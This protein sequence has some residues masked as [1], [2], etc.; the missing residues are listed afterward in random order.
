MTV[1]CSNYAQQY[2]QAWDTCNEANTVVA[3]TAQDCDAYAL[4]QA[5]GGNGP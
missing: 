3:I 4:S 2:Q 1:N 5:N